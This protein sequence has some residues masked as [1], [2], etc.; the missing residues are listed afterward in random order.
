MG[1]PELKDIDVVVLAGGLGTRLQSVVPDL[2]KVMAP[3]DGRPF[4]HHL[5]QW[6]ASQGARRV[7]LSLG[8]KSG[9]VTEFLRAQPYAPLEVHTVIEPQPLGTAG[10]I[11]FALPFIQSDPVLVMNGDTL[12]HADLA[13]FL[14][15]HNDSGAG[16]SVL[17]IRM[18]DPA[19]YGRVDIDSR[20]RIVRFEEKSAGASPGWVNAGAYLFSR[21]ALDSM[22]KIERGSLERD[23]LERMPPGSIHACRASGSFLDVGTPESL[24]QAADFLDR[25]KDACRA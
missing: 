4:L 9:A 2:P 20:N 15:S 18:E 13:N 21:S 25:R 6:L 7:V 10:A 22:T 3:V 23:F 24:A 8:A 14:S 1:R 11:A 17:C 5:L 19:R 12:I 16:V